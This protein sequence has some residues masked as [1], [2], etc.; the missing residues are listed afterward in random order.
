MSSIKV[1]EDAHDTSLST[2]QLEEK[3][4]GMRF[5]SNSGLKGGALWRHVLCSNSLTLSPEWRNIMRLEGFGPVEHSYEDW[6]TKV[7]VEDIKEL[8][9]IVEQAARGEREDVNVIFRMQREDG[10]WAWLLA[11]GK[12]ERGLDGKALD[13]HGTVTDIS[14]LRADPKFQHGNLG[15]GDSAY[16]AMLENSPDLLVRMDR[17]LFPLYINPVVSRYMGREAHEYSFSEDLE[18]LKLDP[19]HLL[20]LKEN[21]EYVFERKK[22]V[23]EMVSFIDAFGHEVTGEYSFWPEFDA[24]GNVIS[25]M[26]QFRDLTE[27]VEAEKSARH[28]ARRLDALYRLSQMVDSPE[29]EVMRFVLHCM[30]DLT[31]S[32]SGFV[33]IPRN[34]IDEPGQVAW[35]A[36][37]QRFYSTNFSLKGSFLDG[38]RLKGAKEGDCASYRLLLNGKG[39]VPVIDSLEEVF[40]IYRAAIAPICEE[41][42]L[43][44][45][46]G[47]GNKGKDY[48][49]ADLKQLEMFISGAW[50]VLRR[51]AHFR[52]LRI[53][54]EAAEHANRVKDEFL[55]NVSHELRTPLNGLLSM[56]QL[57]EAMPLSDEL[58]EYIRAANLSGNALLRIISDILDY[59]RMAHGKMELRKEVFSL[60][61]TIES[62]LSLF[63]GEA[64]QKDLD[65]FYV[66]DE[67]IPD[68]LMGDDARVRQIVFNL[69]GN[70]LK[71]TDKGAI[72]VECLYADKSQ[73]K[74]R[75]QV[76]FKVT[77]T[78]IGIPGEQQ[79]RIFDAF[80]QVDSSSTRKYAGT[81]LGLS[82]VKHLVALMNGAISLES[83]VGVGTR[84][85]CALEFD[86][87]SLARDAAPSSLQLPGGAA[88]PLDVL[89]AEDDSVSRFALRS[90]L[91]RLGHRA[92]CV[93]NG[94]EAIG[95]LKL[96]PFHCL[97][98]DIQM[99]DMDG[100]ELAERV[101]RNEVSDVPVTERI[102]DLLQ[103]AFPDKTLRES[104]IDVEIAIVAVSAH[105]MAGDRERFLQ[106][107]MNDFIS[108]PVVAD[109][110]AACLNKIAS[111]LVENGRLFPGAPRSAEA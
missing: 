20:F 22:S 14:A 46:V 41:E 56:L 44:C 92:V 104:P 91:R 49:E 15:V 74:D 9:E 47:V 10:C 53:A 59:S 94:A 97:L 13:I 52:D 68:R 105:A 37:D 43:V 30:I 5:D 50:L 87:P 34:A 28:N 88:V 25:A 67:R 8:K 64:K 12:L 101:R 7:H 81:G 62:T 51:H 60:K 36:G 107:G 66:I 85:S 45:L 80:T 38:L 32:R 110:L 98:T 70:A 48:V 57:M 11:W 54:K 72:S 21:V 73:G 24:E 103:E 33:F 89:V 58:L 83:E 19:D 2:E 93:D 55:A 84:I 63:K 27:Q 39:D 82:I 106:R 77:D 3:W 75:A 79:S 108:K 29:E 23:R 86:L 35:S 6:A 111:E 96:Y 17:E 61:Q 65:F 18:E 71:F 78:G 102:R 100:M 26:T 40:D 109:E 95:A 90:F 1:I 99:P 76:V 4:E 31:G 16:H 42:K 69:V